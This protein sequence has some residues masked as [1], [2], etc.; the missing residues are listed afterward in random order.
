MLSNP[1]AQEWTPK[2]LHP[3]SC[4]S[5]GSKKILG[6]GPD[7]CVIRCPFFKP[8]DIKT[9]SLP[10]LYMLPFLFSSVSS[11]ILSLLQIIGEEEQN[12]CWRMAIYVVHALSLPSRLNLILPRF[13]PILAISVVHFSRFYSRHSSENLLSIPPFCFSR[14]YSQKA[15][16]K[17]KV[18]K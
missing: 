12:L 5:L 10:L 3:S 7:V 14:I 6:R 2:N 15:K 4:D 8:K 16:L 17:L 18:L 11:Q 9:F 1:K 13:R